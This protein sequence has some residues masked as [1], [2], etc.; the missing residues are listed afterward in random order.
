MSGVSVTFTLEGQKK[1]QALF[2]QLS[3]AIEHTTPIMRA[4]GVGLI[5]NTHQRFE[6]AA[7][8][9][10]QAWAALNPAYAAGKRGPGILR[11]SAMRGGLMGSITQRAGAHEVE[12]GSNKIYAAIHQFGGAI[13]PK[14]APYLVFRLG[15]RVVHARSVTI[16]ARPYLG[17]SRED[18]LTIMETLED[19]LARAVRRG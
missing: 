11:G 19:A 3:L 2:A 15:G 10:G 17:I 8:P 1:V 18:E 6:R 5:E 14:S 12:V 13:K 16:P 4:I 9:D 7:G